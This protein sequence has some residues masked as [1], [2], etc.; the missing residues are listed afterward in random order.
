MEEWYDLTLG[1]DQALFLEKEQKCSRG[2]TAGDR[3]AKG[4][5][6]Y[7]ICILCPSREGSP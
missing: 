3:L 2:Q 4:E 7:V 6:G 1:E 5:G